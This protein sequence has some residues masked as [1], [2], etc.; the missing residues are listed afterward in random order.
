ME[1][2]DFAGFGSTDNATIEAARWFRAGSE[3]AGIDSTGSRY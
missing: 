2:H 1:L 3:N